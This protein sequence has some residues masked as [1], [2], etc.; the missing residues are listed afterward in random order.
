MKKIIYVCLITVFCIML[1][2]ACANKG[3]NAT[4]TQSIDQTE[5]N[6]LNNASPQ[7]EEGQSDSSIIAESS[8][9]I[10][11]KEKEEIINDLSNQ[12]DS[13]LNNVNDL[14]DLND[15]D[16]NVDNID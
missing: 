9:A 16:L 15:S 1:I 12:L 3:E 14:E 10:S 2:S 8:N 13:A 5:T 4:E 6:D 7:N 11:D